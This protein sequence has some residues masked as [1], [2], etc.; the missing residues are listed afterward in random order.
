MR[1]VVVGSFVGFVLAAAFLAACGSGGTEDGVGAPAPISTPSAVK[2]TPLG[3]RTSYVTGVNL[4]RNDIWRG[5]AIYDNARA[6]T[7]HQYATFDLGANV[8]SFTTSVGTIDVGILPAADGNLFATD[9][10]WV[11]SVDFAAA[12]NRRAS[13]VNVRIPPMRFML[14]LRLR[15]SASASA[16]V[17]AFGITP[18]S[19]ELQ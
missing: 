5:T 7:R 3:T 14:A 11:G 17:V 8:E 18:Y 4:T 13:L 10:V 16:R 19:E 15:A 6:G 9:P 2:W 1:N 12:D